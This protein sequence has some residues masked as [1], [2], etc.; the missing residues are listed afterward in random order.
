MP[1][2][3]FPQA[4][5]EIARVAIEEKLI[6]KAC[7]DFE[8]RRALIEH[9]RETIAAETG[10]VLA[11]TVSVEVHEETAA[12]LHLVLPLQLTQGDELS[13]VQLGRVAGGAVP[14]SGLCDLTA[15]QP[16]YSSL[17]GKADK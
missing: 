11:D 3:S 16:A 8:F 2:S 12:R 1:H 15:Q 7:S 17:S 6:S 13:D 4:S 14:I 10:V 5:L 9:P